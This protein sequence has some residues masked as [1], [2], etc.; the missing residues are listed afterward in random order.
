LV[1]LVTCQVVVGRLSH[2]AS[3][4]WSSASIDLLHEIPLY[5]LLE[6]VTGKPARE[7]LHGGA[8]QPPP[9]PTGQRPLHTA[10]SCQVHPRGDTYFD[11]FPNLL[12]IS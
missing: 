10:S 7:R 8:A 5:H 6:S 2:V 3:Q 11:G 12:V 9:G 4:P 1:K